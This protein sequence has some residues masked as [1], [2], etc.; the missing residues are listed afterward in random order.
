MA[1]KRMLKKHWK[2]F[3]ILVCICGALLL[4]RWAAMLWG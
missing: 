3:L 1:T 2:M 4:L